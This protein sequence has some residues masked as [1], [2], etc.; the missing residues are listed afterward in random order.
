MTR[1]SRCRCRR[2]SSS[3]SR[4]ARP[5]GSSPARPA[6]W[7]GSTSRPTSARWCTRWPSGS[8]PASSRPVPTVS[9]SSWATSSRSGTAWSSG[10]RGPRP[11]SSSGSGPRWPASSPG[12]TPTPA[13]VV[14]IEEPFRAVLELPNGERVSLGGYADRLELDAD[15]RVVV[16]DLKTGRTKPSDKSVLTNVQL[17]LYQ[18]AVDHGAADELVDQ[19]ARA[20]GAELV[21]L[22]LHRRRRAR[23]RPAP[24]GPGRRRPR[25][26]G[27]ARSAGQGGRAV[28]QR[29]LPRGRRPALPRLRLRPDLPD[30]ERRARWSAS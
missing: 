24:A 15:G 26:G 18:L 19:E 22:G 6:A 2:A 11:A 13:R 10:R 8:P 14:G 7:P 29:E 27:A 5:S 3:T 16:V 28:A 4:C 20:G 1:T 25:A 12:T 9:T 21:Q 30:Q 17:G 23:H